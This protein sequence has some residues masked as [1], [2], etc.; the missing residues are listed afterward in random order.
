MYLPSVRLFWPGD[1]PDGHRSGT[2]VSIRVARGMA[3]PAINAGADEVL[4]SD[5]R[6]F[7]PGKVTETGNEIVSRFPFEEDLLGEP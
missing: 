2:A 1:S 3:F 4:M 7:G 5:P 6:G